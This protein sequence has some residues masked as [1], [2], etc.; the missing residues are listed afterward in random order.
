M[1]YGNTPTVPNLP[2]PLGGGI[3]G[4]FQGISVAL[5]RGTGTIIPRPSPCPLSLPLLL[6]LSIIAM[7]KAKAP[8]PPTASSSSPPSS[9]CAPCLT[10]IVEVVTQWN[11]TLLPSCPHCHYYLPHSPSFIVVIKLLCCCCCHHCHFC[12]HRRILSYSYMVSFLLN[13]WYLVFHMYGGGELMPQTQ[14]WWIPR[15]PPMWSPRFPPNF[16]VCTHSTDFSLQSVRCWWNGWP[17]YLLVAPNKTKKCDFVCGGIF[18]KFYSK[19]WPAAKI[20]RGISTD[21]VV[22][23]S[24]YGFGRRW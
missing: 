6:F 12:R 2:R 22:Y 1:S 5:Y 11:P 18:L 14:I 4:D 17:W 24:S 16:W 20:N 7:V 9:S 13:L 3:W 21:W 19:D 23:L 8:P 15:W 10:F